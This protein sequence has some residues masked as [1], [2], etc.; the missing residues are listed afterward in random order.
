MDHYSHSLTRYRILQTIYRTRKKLLIPALLLISFEAFPRD[1]INED[2]FSTSDTLVQPT[3][4]QQSDSISNLNSGPAEKT[5][6]TS[7]NE[8]LQEWKIKL[9]DQLTSSPDTAEKRGKYPQHQDFSGY[10]GKIIRKIEFRQLEVF[11]QTIS[12][13]SEVPTKWIEKLGNGLHIK[14]QRYTL[15][16]RLLLKP[17]DTLNAFI[18]SENE[19]LYRDL[20]Y[21]DDAI[22]FIRPARNDSIDILFVTKDIFPLGGGLE[23]LDVLYGKASIYNKNL[24][25]IGH[26][27]NYQITWNQDTIPLYGHKLRYSIPTI[28]NTFFSADASYENNWNL[29][30]FN[31][32]LQRKFFTSN[33][34]SAGGVGFEKVRSRRDIILPDTVYKGID[35]DYNLYEIWVGKAFNIY[36]VSTSQQ[37]TNFTLTGKI[38]RYEFY[39]RPEVNES[40]LYAFQERITYLITAGISAQGY[41]K[42]QFIHGFG[43]TEDIPFG[44]TVSLTAGIED[45]EF[46][47]RPYAGFLFSRASGMSRYGR[48]YHEINFGTFFHH[49]IEQGLLD[50]SLNYFTP[51]L[52]NE[53]RFNYRIFAGLRYKTGLNRFADEYM[54]FTRND[55]I[56]GLKSD[57]LRG[58]QRFN[59][60]LESVCYPP[61]QVLGFRFHYFVFLD[62]GIISRTS[63]ILI[64]NHMY[65]GFGAGIRIRNDNLAFNTVQIRLALYPML[66]DNSSPEYIQL[67]GIGNPRFEDFFIQ[68]PEII[69]YQVR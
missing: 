31:F 50:I 24:M 60:N 12:D 8:R 1:D 18:L 37:Q 17:G 33:I 29:E 66:P 14:T 64:R 65:T 23:L 38:T 46:H 10:E 57:E 53:G 62:A 69:L 21:I 9:I 39:N 34:N 49:G 44:F 58:N 15:R 36:S 42:N 54:E 3:I 16:N 63:D 55:G 61:H 41:R 67:A 2:L 45:N 5:D 52:N 13:T 27:F 43:R 59:I 32:H 11:G 51:L 68:Q 6:S 25:G 30:E 22:A 40:F 28:G 19:R 4:G 7:R 20:P 26:E 35:L 56:R 48:I 47:N